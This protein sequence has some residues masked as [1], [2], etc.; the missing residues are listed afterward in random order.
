M[1]SYLTLVMFGGFLYRMYCGVEKRDK[2][3][4]TEPWCGMNV[5]DLMD[6]ETDTSDTWEGFEYNSSYCSSP[7]SEENKTC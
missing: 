3:T 1:L 4:Q 2:Q 7:Q 6:I 5:I